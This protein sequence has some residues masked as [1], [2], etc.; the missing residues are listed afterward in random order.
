MPRSSNGIIYLLLTSC[1]EYIF[2]RLLGDPITKI[3]QISND[4][5]VLQVSCLGTLEDE[6]AE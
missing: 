5:M 4:D 1:Y 6:E 3:P 2:K